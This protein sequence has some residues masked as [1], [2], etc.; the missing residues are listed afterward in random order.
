MRIRPFRDDDAPILAELF[1]AAVHGVG[2]HYYSAEQVAAWS[3]APADPARFVARGR[4]GRTLLVAVDEDDRPIAYGDVEG[5]G[6]VDHLY[7]AP[8]HAGTGVT[9]ALYAAIEAAARGRGVVCLTVEASEPARR[10]FLKQGF[11]EVHRR[12][13]EIGGVAIHNYAMEKRLG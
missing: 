7:C 2:A 3:P 5:D 9:A 1:H 12:D 6:H 4:D 13:F 10:F 11:R 8:E